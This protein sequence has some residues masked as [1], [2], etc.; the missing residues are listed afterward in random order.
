MHAKLGASIKV[1][2]PLVTLFSEDPNLLD[3]PESILRETLH[4]S[5]TPPQTQPLIRE[6][7]TK[8]DLR[9]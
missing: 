6:V 1:D 4:I 5:S 8:D 2:Q 7:V 9:K 3:E